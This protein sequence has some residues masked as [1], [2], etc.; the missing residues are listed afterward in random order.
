MRRRFAVRGTHDNLVAV[1][2]VRWLYCEP[3]IRKFGALQ[4][5]APVG[6][7]LACKW[8]RA[9]FTTMRPVRKRASRSENP[10]SLFWR[11][12]VTSLASLLS[13]RRQYFCVVLACY[14]HEPLH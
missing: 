5:A 6:N 8:T 3:L 11:G 1:P 12:P 9:A 10:D 4:E 7:V 14:L 13:R 2:G